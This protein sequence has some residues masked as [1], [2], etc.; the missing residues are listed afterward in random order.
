LKKKIDGLLTVFLAV[1]L[2]LAMS[3][4]IYA[5][6]SNIVSKD[7]LT[8]QMFTD[9]DSYKIN[10][11]ID[12][13]VRV[14]NQTGQEVYIL[15]NVKVPDNVKLAG[16]A[17]QD[18]ILQK[19]G[20]WDVSNMQME[21]IENV[22]TGGSVATGDDTSWVWIAPAIVAAC[23]LVFMTV[24]GKKRKLWLP[25][26]L[27]LAMLGGLVIPAI[28]VQAAGRSGEIELSCFIQVDG[29]QEEVSTTISYTIM[30]D[31]F[32]IEKTETPSESGDTTVSSESTAPSEPITPT[33]PSEPEEPSEPSNPITSEEPT[34]PSDPVVPEEPTDPSEPTTPD[35][36]IGPQ[37][38]LSNGG[39]EELST[40]GAPVGWSFSGGALG[41]MFKIDTTE[42]AGG[43]NSLYCKSDNFDTKALA[44]NG[45]SGMVKDTEY[46]LS[47][48][49]KVKDARKIAV[50]LEFSDIDE[51][52]VL[53][54]LPGEQ[55]IQQTVTEFASEEWIDYNYTFTAP[56]SLASI[57]ARFYGGEVWFDDISVIGEKATASGSDDGDNTAM[58][59]K[60]PLPGAQNM[61]VNGSFEELDAAGKPI[62]WVELNNLAATEE[63]TG[64]FCSKELWD[65]SSAI[66][67]E[68]VSSDDGGAYD[69]THA[70]RIT[71]TEGLSHPYVGFFLRDIE[72]G[73]EYQVRAW[74]NQI[75]T[76]TVG[77]MI[78]V[79]F[80]SDED[81]A[82][83][84][85]PVTGEMVS[86]NLGVYTR[87]NF[88]PA[89]P[90]WKQV[91]TTFTVPENCKLACV[92]LRVHDTGEVMYDQVECYQTGEPEIVLYETDNVFYYSDWTEGNAKVTKNP[93]LNTDLTGA[94]VSFVLKDEAGT[95]LQKAD[96]V[97][98]TDGEAQFTFSLDQLTAKK[99]PYSVEFRCANASGEVIDEGSQTIYKYDRPLLIS[100]EGV[101]LR[102]VLK[103]DGT[104]EAGEEFLPI[105][106][107]HVRPTDYEYCKQAGINLIQLNMG[108]NT[109]VESMKATLDEL[110]ENDLYALVFLYFNMK[111]AGNEA[112]QKSTERIVN[113]IKDHPAV[114][115]WLCMDEPFLNGSK[116]EDL[117]AGYKIIHDIDNVH[118]IYLVEAQTHADFY[119]NA[120]K[121]CDVLAIDPYPTPIGTGEKPMED[122][123]LKNTLLAKEM[124]NGK[125]PIWVI[126]QSMIKHSVPEFF[127]PTSNDILHMNYQ[128]LM[129]GAEGLGY[130]D[131]QDL[132][133]YKAD[134]T[135]EHMWDRQHWPGI[136]YFKD[137]ELD[138][139]FKT[140]VTE[141]YT[142]I[143]NSADPNGN[144]WWRTYK[145]VNDDAL[146]AVMINITAQAQTISIPL[147]M[148]G[149]N[150]IGEFTAV[151]DTISNIGTKTGTD[152]LTLELTPAQCAIFKITLGNDGTGGNEGNGGNEGGQTPGEGEGTG[153]NEGGQTPGEG[154][155]TGGNEGGETQAENLVKNGDFAG[156]A[157]TTWQLKNNATIETTGGRSNNPVLY[158]NPVGNNSSEYAI[159]KVTGLEIGQEY[160]VTFWAKQKNSKKFFANLDLYNSASTKIGSLKIEE[161]GSK[162]EEWVEYSS[163]FTAVG[164]KID[165]YL[166]GYA[167]ATP[168]CEI[169]FDDISI[170]KAETAETTEQNIILNGDFAG[171]ASAVWQL[172]N[173]ATIETVGGKDN[174]PALYCNPVGNDKSEYAIQS[175]SNLERG[176]DYILTFWAKQSNSKK[177]FG[178]IKLYNDSN[179]QVRDI[180]VEKTGSTEEG[181]V[182]YSLPF[183]AAGLKVDLY[184]Q[185]YAKDDNG[186][187]VWFDDISIV[188]TETDDNTSSGDNTG[189]G[190]GTTSVNLFSVGNFEGE[191]SA[192]WTLKNGVTIVDGAGK[193]NSKALYL[194][195]SEYGTS[196][197]SGLTVGEEYTVSV[198]VKQKNANK[199]V[200]KLDNG[201]NILFLDRRYEPSE[202]VQDWTE[203]S[204]TFTAFATEINI[205]LNAYA[206]SGS[207]CEVWIDDIS[208]MKMEEN[209]SNASDNL[210]TVGD[211]E[212]ETSASWTLKSG[213]T[214]V[215]GAGKGNSKA[216]YLKQSEYGASRITGL[217]V[218][219]EYTVSV[220]IKQKNANKIVLTLVNGNNKLLLD[221]RYEP[222]ETV[223]EWTELSATFTAF[224]TETDINLNAYAAENAACEVWFDDI[225]VVETK[226]PVTTAE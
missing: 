20:S 147:S 224:A 3:I 90:G 161:T 191:A 143:S 208:V 179:V 204:A 183:T 43:E 7:G 93:L 28:P 44:I 151:S 89:Q 146:Y 111:P 145:K 91:A 47:F 181:W 199:I 73:A 83:V 188:K 68:E 170:M 41:N 144:V 182:E 103:A 64:W 62:N 194:K 25:V 117:A 216:L 109:S 119:D 45:F 209:Q 92:F 79:E 98:I 130:Y 198:W 82:K 126:N 63:S 131:V 201:S 217:T 159:Q 203:S 132:Y 76:A 196:K 33:E 29:K 85:D 189:S 36:P 70:V 120:G 95:V 134:G 99:I 215:D 6:Q 149:T 78:K 27:C 123:I 21:E 61:V 55:D 32:V 200:L 173:N 107:Y 65:G 106:G 14:D 86:S 18:A 180:K 59:L 11:T 67:L 165:L 163:T 185:A 184:L 202:T 102:P 40:S 10:E 154:E 213:V 178:D 35:E 97:A 152:T 148:D 207:T 186:C 80:F 69:G 112:N 174:G 96:D 88:A 138:T 50:K 71:T 2:F 166:Q 22:K 162:E 133:G 19:G 169:W 114:Y 110:A 81:K 53:V 105:V 172:K 206:A 37:E 197:I 175:I 135:Y 77:G 38:L 222:S 115:A 128:A 124:T 190:E 129:A 72:P 51:S 125:K 116:E 46:T 74:L 193:G 48:K 49:A 155:G 121:Y 104:I 16:N 176:K 150:P 56:G 226:V 168:D 8:A 9:K 167:S 219:K 220:W 75:N 54:R 42:K 223:Q 192:S 94:K 164:E 221:R 101:S 137:N 157:S 13:A 177:F 23:C 156:E 127:K 58:N 205:N 211:F 15:T 113:A 12:V 60:D 87:D 136:K 122:N 212:G 1:V 30:E 142:T 195:Q 139:A 24:Y 158:C 108:Q 34:E 5:A 153:G 214:I 52:G 66:S 140:F 225:L 100:A 39:F 160:T 118:P 17:I 210:F 57:Y 218:G 187:Q 4:H 141:D 26:L 171:E 31:G 84:Q